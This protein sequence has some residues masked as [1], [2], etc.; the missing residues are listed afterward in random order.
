MRIS[1]F[2]F[3]IFLPVALLGTIVVSCVKQEFDEPPLGGD[4]VVL[5]PNTT[6]AELKALH[7]TDGGYDKITEDLTIGGVVIMDD[8]SGNYYKTLVIQDE[9]GGIEVKFNDGFLFN[10]FPVGRTIYIHCQDLILTDYN[11]LIQL[12]GS[13]VSSGGQLDDVGLTESQVRAKVEKG[14]ISTTPP[15][16]KVVTLSQISSQ[17]VSTLIR[18]EDVQFIKAD[19]GMTYADP[20]T[21][22]N[23]NRTLEDCN[24]LELIVRTSGYADFAGELTPGGKGTITGVLS[25]YGNTLQM[26]IRDLNDVQMDSLRC[27]VIPGGGDG[28]TSLFESFEGASSGQDLDLSGWVNVAVAGN[29]L[30]RAS[31]FS[32][33]T[34]ASATAYNSNLADM[35]TWLITPALDLSSQLTLNFTSSSGYYTHDGLTVWVSTD[36]DGQDVNGATWTE[37]AFNK[38]AGDAN[39]YTDFVPSGAIDLPVFAGK[40]YVGFKYSG[41]TTTNTTTW[42]FDN[43]EIE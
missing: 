4:P 20:V 28:L 23:L 29:R 22:F 25:V 11:N 33:S 12:T 31:S 24:G 30:W 15:A 18:L 8:R 36:F 6:I 2:F 10:Q 35:Q 39:G 32:N 14:A 37:L 9:T 26:Y 38:P 3:Q 19:T 5:T 17:D 1:K 34:F 41:N 43:I 27:G 16:P 13:L 42:R 7:I 40:G 21:N